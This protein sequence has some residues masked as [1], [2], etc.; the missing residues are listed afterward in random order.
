[1]SDE[2][3]RKRDEAVEKFKTEIIT[4]L[5]PHYKRAGIVLDRL[6]NK[7]ADYLIIQA[8][9][10][11]INIDRLKK[12]LDA[13][14]EEAQG[15]RVDPEYLAL[16]FK[17]PEK[18]SIPLARNDGRVPFTIPFDTNGK[19]TENPREKKRRRTTPTSKGGR[20][21]HTRRRPRRRV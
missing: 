13:I 4:S 21:L 8:P 14:I 7:I 15:L 9:E 12:S 11:Q 3:A 20:R 10:H 1:M 17:T 19:G 5:V 2:A 6:F 18:P 16:Q